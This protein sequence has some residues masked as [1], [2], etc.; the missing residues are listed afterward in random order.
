MSDDHSL[1]KLGDSS[2]EAVES[3]LKTFCPD[4]V[5]R[6]AATVL[7]SSTPPLETIALPAVVTSVAYVD[8]VHGGN[9]FAMTRIGARKLAAAMMG[10]DPAALVDDQELSELELSAVGEAMNQMMA[11]AAGAISKVLGEEVEIAPP[12]TLF[13][14]SPDEAAAAFEVAPHVVSVAF[15]VLG[16]PC[17]LVQLV[18]NAFVVRMGRALAELEAELVPA[19]GAE[20]ALSPELLRQVPLQVCVELGRT[21]MPIA[22][23]VGLPHGAVVELDRDADEPVGLYVNGRLFARGTLVVADGTEWAVRIDDLLPAAAAGATTPERG[24]GS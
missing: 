15:V 6:G 3:V 5:E 24:E 16:E 19:A 17:R 20:G 8:G 4:G 1:L 2:G 14:A 7:P 11:V 23:A 9:I 22:R 18:P 21:R 12:Q 13:L 10:E